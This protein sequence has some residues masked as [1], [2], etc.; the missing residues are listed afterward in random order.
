MGYTPYNELQY[1][2]TRGKSF[3]AD[4]VIVAFCMNDVVNPRLHWG[5]VPGVRIPREA[6]PNHDY[7][8]NHILPRIQKRKEEQQAR[9]ANPKGGGPPLLRHSELYSLLDRGIER[10]LRKKTKSHADNSSGLPTYITGEDTLSIEVL[11]DRTSPEWR[12][13]ASIYDRLNDAVRADRAKLVIVIFPLAY[14]L[15]PH[16]PFL[17][18]ERIVEYCRQNSIPCIDLLPSFRRHPKEDIFLLDKQ[19]FYDIWHLTEY[20]HRLSAEEVLR[21]LRE[22][23]LLSEER[24]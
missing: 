14:Q 9:A 12:W 15:D 22:E 8:Q 18:Q 7:D 20:G 11:L 13:L 6:I 21:F 19:G 2:L 4:V 23:E 5:E 3:E 16:Y 1:Y 10:I 24:K 17:P